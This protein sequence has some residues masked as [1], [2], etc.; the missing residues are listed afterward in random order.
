MTSP[1]ASDEVNR[2]FDGDYSSSKPSKFRF[3]SERHSSSH[4]ADRHSSHSSRKRYASSRSQ[5]HHHHHH[6]SKRRKHWHSQ[7]PPDD[8]SL[9]DD[10]HLPNTSSKYYLPP[11][12]AFR[13]SLFDALADDEGAAF[14]E[15]VYGQPIHT[16]ASTRPGPQGELEQM[17]DEEYAA[18]VRAK[19]YEKTHQHIIEEKARLEE[20]RKK[21]KEFTEHINKVRKER[22]GFER[23]VEESLRRGQERKR[24]K[25]W[26]EIWEGY[27]RG[28]EELKRGELGGEDEVDG[29]SARR[30]IRDSIPWPVESGRWKDVNREEVER[31]IRKAPFA[32]SGSDTL[33]SDLA[34]L[35]KVERVRW[36]PD[37]I[38]QRLGSNGVDEST[39]KAVTAVFQ[40]LDSMLTEARQ[41]R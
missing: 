33:P 21:Q 26:K 20:A 1:T 28:W 40:I 39:M 13:E 30:R 15:G 32:N 17:T 19:M 14:W 9:Y 31:F 35:L 8:P 7:Q 3:K 37:K 2:R 34:G 24:E 25:K 27:V 38:Q 6:R 36:H 29:G 18:H 41:S 10:T 12:A 22:N 23:A 5:E 16:Y 4:D 11:D